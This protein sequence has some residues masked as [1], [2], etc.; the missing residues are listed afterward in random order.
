[1]INHNFD[2]SIF[3]IDSFTEINLPFRVN[4]GDI[5]DLDQLIYFEKDERV[6]NELFEKVANKDLYFIVKKCEP[7]IDEDDICIFIYGDVQKGKG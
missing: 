5:F 2:L 7:Y 3:K 6:K 1:M 4:V